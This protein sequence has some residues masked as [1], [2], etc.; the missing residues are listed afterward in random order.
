MFNSDYRMVNLIK[1][2]L[3]EKIWK[4]MTKMKQADSIVTGKRKLTWSKNLQKE[5]L[6][7][8]K[9]Q[10]FYEIKTSWN[11]FTPINGHCAYKTHK[12]LDYWKNSDR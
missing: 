11:L 2:I 7:E 8:K 9:M 5:K 6:C 4:W 3:K 10:T 1:T 12:C